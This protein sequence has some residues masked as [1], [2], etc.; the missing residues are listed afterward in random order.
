MVVLWY[1]AKPGVRCCTLAC[2]PFEHP[3]IMLQQRRHA[4]LKHQMMAM[5]ANKAVRDHSFCESECSKQL[6]PNLPA[7]FCFAPPAPATVT[8]PYAITQ[9]TVLRYQQTSDKSK[10]TFSITERAR[11]GEVKQPERRRRPETIRSQDQRS[12]CRTSYHLDSG[13][14]DARDGRRATQDILVAC[15]RELAHLPARRSNA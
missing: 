4:L 11:D 2:S 10:G 14:Q 6:S 8:A 3:H 5:T 7:P 15:E 1:G 9:G 12:R 13:S